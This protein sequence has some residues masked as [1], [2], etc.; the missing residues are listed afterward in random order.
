MEK[1]LKI[2]SIE[3]AILAYKVILTIRHQKNRQNG[4]KKTL[5][6]NE[7]SLI[8][9]VFNFALMELRKYQLNHSSKLP[10]AIYLNEKKQVKYLTPNKVTEILRK[11]VRKA[12]P[13][14][15]AHEVMRYSTH[16]IRV[17]ACVLLDEAGKSPDFIKKRLRWLGESYRVYLRD[18]NKINHQHVD[19]LQE[20][21]QAVMDLISSDITD[22][23]EPLSKE[24]TL[25][26]EEYDSG[27]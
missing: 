14:K 16:S 21:S 13:D 3:I 15:P 18:T 6:R 4:E 10:L 7:H 9:P 2:I 17:W 22:V 25:V 24:D 12:Y 23:M 11:A 27:D 19:A 1:M 20:S 26:T 8:C 5:V